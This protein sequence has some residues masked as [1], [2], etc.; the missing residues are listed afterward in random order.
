MR[1]ARALSF[2]VTAAAL[3]FL[4][5]CSSTG[6][7]AEPSTSPTASVTPTADAEAASPSPTPTPTTEPEPEPEP[8]LVPGTYMIGETTE[9]F[10]GGRIT[11]NGLEVVKEIPTVDGEPLAAAE[12]EQLVLLRTRF[13]NTGSSTVDLSC[14]GVPNWYV[15]V[16]D[17]EGR[18][19]APAFDTYR[20]PGNQECNHQLLSGQE[21]DWNFAFRG[22]DGST[23]RV[24]QITDS[25]TFDDW[26]AFALTDEP[27]RLAD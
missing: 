8:T 26:V 23:P 3:T 6:Q 16:F 19:L 24:L 7:D 10:A 20:I 12:G 13:V 17:T 11:L 5:A 9:D 15:Q 27:L 4:A 14:A 18:E 25:R 22:I 2:V 21:A 1:R